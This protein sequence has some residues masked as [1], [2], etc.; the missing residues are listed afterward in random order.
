MLYDAE[1]E[2]IINA[3]DRHSIQA[4]LTNDHDEHQN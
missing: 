3:T 1:T 4:Q 2:N